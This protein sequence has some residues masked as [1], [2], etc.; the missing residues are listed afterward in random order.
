MTSLAEQLRFADADLFTGGASDDFLSASLTALVRKTCNYSASETLREA[1]SLLGSIVQTRL[2]V[3][4]AHE[5][6][7]EGGEEDRP[8][9]WLEQVPAA[10]E[11]L[12]LPE[13]DLASSGAE[14]MG[15]MVSPG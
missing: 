9:V 6:V 15:W 1:G 12:E 10:G 7:D 14:R 4:L 11:G 2:S 3:S 8:V 13:Q 5:D